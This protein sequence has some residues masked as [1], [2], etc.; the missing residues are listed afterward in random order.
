MANGFK[1]CPRCWLP[2]HRSFLYC[3]CCGRARL[4]NEVH[5]NNINLVGVDPMFLEVQP[6][7]PAPL[8]PLHDNAEGDAAVAAVNEA[9]VP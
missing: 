6:G 3:E 9:E 1:R 4:P 8:Q 2:T 5:V 7:A